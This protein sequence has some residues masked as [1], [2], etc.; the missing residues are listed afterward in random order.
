MSSHSHE[1]PFYGKRIV[2][3]NEQQYIKTL[4]ANYRNEPVTEELKQKVYDELIMEKHLGN[5]SIPFRVVV[6]RDV[7]G[8]YPPHIEVILDTKV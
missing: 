6:R 2:R 8:K 7:Y 5:V 4:L 3:D 1:E